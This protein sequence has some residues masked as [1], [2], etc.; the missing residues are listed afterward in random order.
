MT[1]NDFASVLTRI[2]EYAAAYRAG[3]PA[4]SHRPEIGYADMLERLG[5]AIPERG[6]SI[7]AL[8][9]E[10]IER[11]EPGL[12][13]MTGPRFFGWVIG[14]SAPAGMAVD[15]LTSTWAQNTGN[16]HATPSAS[17]IEEVAGQWLLDL[18]DLPRESSVGFVTGATIANF[19]CLAAARG[20]VLRRAGWDCE[21]QGLFGAPPIHVVL[22]EEAHSTVFSALKYLGLGTS[23][24]VSV[25]INREGCMRAEAFEAAMRNLD[26]PI[27][28][29]AQA[30]HINSGAFDPFIEI[31]PIAKQ[32]GAWL[33]VDGAFGLWARA[34]REL[35][36]L[37]AGVELADS[38]GTD[39]H[40]WLQTPY[41]SGYAIVRDRDAH[42]RAMLIAAS[43]LPEGNERHPADYVPELSRRARGFGTWAMIKSLGRTGVADM[44]SGHCALARRMA[45]RL[46]SEG[47]IEIMNEVVLNQV[48]V[49]CGTDFDGERADA[50]TQRAI[51]RIQREGECF[52]GGAVWG[53][54]QIIR[55]SVIGAGTT[56]ADIDRSASAVIAAWRA[57][58]AL[59][60]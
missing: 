44:V 51:A 18:L 60:G 41:D 34:S 22:G 8:V 36:S 7:D 1:Q 19:T 39:G 49:R 55:V 4:R 23:R 50:L 5:G 45:D 29:I 24:V 13:A 28:A 57:E 54:R 21:A 47:D 11:A 32:K 2:A 12:A 35:A 3:A 52:V 58:R 37:G 17:A 30:G 40:K 56:E 48:A 15:W 20:E 10:L 6:A 59:N 33:H 25:A 14:A 26:G 9:T 27:I 38:W 43:Y 31:A 16:A 46:A 53:G 42:R